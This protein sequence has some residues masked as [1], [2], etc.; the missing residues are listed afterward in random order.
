MELL[1]YIDLL[2]TALN[3]FLTLLWKRS[4]YGIYDATKQ[5]LWPQVIEHNFSFSEEPVSMNIE[6][7]LA[8]ISSICSLS[9]DCQSIDIPL[10]SAPTCD[11]SVA[12][13]KQWAWGHTTLLKM[14]FLFPNAIGFVKDFVVASKSSI[15]RFLNFPFSFLRR[16]FSF[17][18]FPIILSEWLYSQTASKSTHP[19]ILTSTQKYL[20]ISNFRNVYW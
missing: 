6:V 7:W 13:F 4:V 16:E 2:R 5:T 8:T 19:S 12:R 20:H 3:I 17:F 18:M 1:N 10:T 15:H 14:K 9:L 11:V